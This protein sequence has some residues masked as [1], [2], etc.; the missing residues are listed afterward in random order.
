MGECIRTWWDYSDSVY[1]VSIIEFLRIAINWVT[2]RRNERKYECSK[3]SCLGFDARKAY[4]DITQAI[5]RNVMVISI[6]FT[7]L[8]FAALQPYFTV[9]MFFFLIMLVS[10]VT[11]L[12]LIPSLLKIFHKSLPGFKD[13]GSC[14][15]EMDKFSKEVIK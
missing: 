7:P 1:V 5:W 6:G 15:V 3:N 4:Q 12:L 14:E 10:G 13:E 8:F 11:T 9:G 2:G